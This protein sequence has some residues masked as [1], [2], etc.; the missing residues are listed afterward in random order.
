MTK[1]EIIEEIDNILNNVENECSQDLMSS[2]RNGID[3]KYEVGEYAFF[4]A[5]DQDEYDFFI[6]D[7]KSQ[8]I[9]ECGYEGSLQFCEWS[10]KSGVSVFMDAFEHDSEQS[11]WD[12]E[13]EWGYTHNNTDVEEF[14]HAELMNMY[15]DAKRLDKEVTKDRKTYNEY[16]D[17]VT[18]IV[19]SMAEGVCI[20]NF[21]NGESIFESTKGVA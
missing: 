8:I 12:F 1:P 13:D 15:W 17:G 6:S 20:G 14:T 11:I 10:S 19:Y 7:M 21:S 9:Y 3:E 4:D 18:K 2:A 5:E 16:V